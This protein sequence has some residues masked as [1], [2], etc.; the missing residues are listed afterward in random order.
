MPHKVVE[1]VK[2]PHETLKFFIF[3]VISQLS[4]KISHINLGFEIF[5]NVLGS[6]DHMVPDS[7]FS[8]KLAIVN[9]CLNITTISSIFQLFLMVF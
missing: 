6:L 7:A 5:S 8:I 3:G 9:Q 2:V 4:F 1:A